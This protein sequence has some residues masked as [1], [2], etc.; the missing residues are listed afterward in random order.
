MFSQVG[1]GYFGDEDE[2]DGDLVKFEREAEA[3][4]WEEALDHLREDLDVALPDPLPTLPE[5]AFISL[6]DSAPSDAPP[7]E[8]AAPGGKRKAPSAAAAAKK[9][10]VDGQAT[11]S[12]ANG[13]VSVLKADDL[14]PPKLLGVKEMEQWIVGKQKAALLAEYLD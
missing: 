8:P 4:A 9:S 1:P 5:A 3:E 10:K 7:Q 2:L 12:S 13:F 6:D 11:A 14:R